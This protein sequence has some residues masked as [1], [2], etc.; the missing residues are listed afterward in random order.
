MKVKKMVKLKADARLVLKP[1]TG[2]RSVSFLGKYLTQDKRA[3]GADFINCADELKTKG[4]WWD[5]MDMTR[6]TFDHDTAYK[7]RKAV[8]Y[9]HF[10][11]SPDP[12]DNVDLESL[13]DFA[14][15]WAKK[16]YP[17]YEVAIVYHDDNDNG[18]LHAHVVVNVSNLATG[19]KLKTSNNFMNEYTSGLQDMAEKRGWGKFSTAKP[20]PEPKG[21]KTVTFTK[22]GKRKEENR[23]T[24]SKAFDKR[25]QEKSKKKD[26]NYYSWKGEIEERV[27]V[28]MSMSTTEKQF[29][30]NLAA[31]NIT[32]LTAK[33][34]DYKFAFSNE[35][36]KCCNG[37]NLA[38]D[39]SGRYD[40]TTVLN[41]LFTQAIDKI[42]AGSPEYIDNVV[43]TL[44]DFKA[45]KGVHHISLKSDSNMTLSEFADALELHT[46]Y[47]I[48]SLADY[49]VL[50][51]NITDVDERSNLLKF[52]T[53]AQES[54]M[55]EGVNAPIV[56]SYTH[57]RPS[58]KRSTESITEQERIANLWAATIRERR[59]GD[60]KKK[61]KEDEVLATDDDGPSTNMSQPQQ[62]ELPGKRRR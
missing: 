55:F 58:P 15:E 61:K 49:D 57:P 20:E 3:L 59:D 6:R 48:T 16:F 22:D 54:G 4:R 25:P 32:V 41:D 40:K 28:A 44:E 50:I 10:V 53:I 1:I 8:T 62:K 39:R 47:H 7:N 60:G 43:R 18:I 34:G 45:G 42:L 17:D 56:Y 14:K 13:R 30:A 51:A 33:N 36:T 5:Q 2:H 52:R 27:R 35:I 19:E 46:E 26:S 31:Q 11:L 9:R 24:K 21:L 23:A 37:R 38:A 29:I 12:K